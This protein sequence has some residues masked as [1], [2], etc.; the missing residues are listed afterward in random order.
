MLLQ[1]ATAAVL[2]EDLSVL[3]VVMVVHEAAGDVTVQTALMEARLLTGPRALYKRFE[4]ALREAMD[5]SAFGNRSGSPI[6]SNTTL[7]P[8]PPVI[9]I[10]SAVRS[11][12]R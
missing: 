6:F 4:Q 3:E 8:A 10:T 12:A 5:A 11:C 7:T 9:F 2:E 1:A